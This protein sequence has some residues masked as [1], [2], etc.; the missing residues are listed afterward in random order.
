MRGALELASAGVLF[1]YVERDI[2]KRNET[3]VAFSSVCYH[4]KLN[5]LYSP[6]PA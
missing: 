2:S 5:A 3:D 1:S 6:S 4:L